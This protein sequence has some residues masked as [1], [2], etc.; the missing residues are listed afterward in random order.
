MNRY[1]SID[2]LRG[3]IMVI[4]AIDHALGVW[5]VGKNYFPEIALPASESQQFGPQF[6][7]YTDYRDPATQF[8]RVVTHVCAPGF[9]LLAGL[10]L[11]ISVAR[12]RRQGMSELKITGD[13]ALRGFVLI[14]CDWFL[15][16]F[17]YMGVWLFWMVL[18]CI[19]AAT[20]LF[21][22]L[23]FWPLPLIGCF[24]AAVLLL[25]PLYCPAAIDSASAANYV[26]AIWGR[27]VL[28]GS[29]PA[30]FILY[31]IFPW[32][33]LFGLGWVLGTVYESRP[34]DRFKWLI[35]LGLG[36]ILF[37][38]ALR[39]FAGTYGDRMP[40]GD[41]GPFTLPF[42][43][44]SKY[45]PSPVFT[46]TTL[47]WLLLMLGLL[48][49]LDFQESP[50][51]NW[52]Y[53]AVLGR[54]ALFFY[55]VHFYFFGVTWFSYAM[56]HKQYWFDPNLPKP[57]NV[58]AKVPLGWAYVVWVI[59]LLAVWPLCWWYDKMRQKHKRVLRYF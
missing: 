5:Y 4:M 2:T 10:G 52:Q 15:M 57:W 22:V 53:L 29:Q 23:R 39:W 17:M 36:V 16:H 37:G 43:V 27:I 3:L 45:P 55:V 24:S 28:G 12:S 31:P 19:G 35:P 49:P 32:I 8:S 7:P 38:L 26:H 11:A 13:M 20:M 25:Q 33:G 21:S 46:L 44:W 6:N 18:C 59:G 58:Q 50:S 30:Y 9:Q 47:G 48:R 54:V 41:G 42:W 1:L 40:G 34:L 56:L 51:P 14:L